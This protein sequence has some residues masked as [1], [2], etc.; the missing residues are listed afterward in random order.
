MRRF[1][2][3]LFPLAAS[4]AYRKSVPLHPHRNAKLDFT[5]RV[6][7]RFTSV[8]DPLRERSEALGAANAVTF[9]PSGKGSCRQSL[10]Y[11]DLAGRAQ[12]VATA[13][14]QRTRPGDRVL[15]AMDSGL[16][17][18][19]S[20]FGC[21]IARRIA[22]PFWAAGGGRVQERFARVLD[23]AAA[24][25][26]LVDGAGD[27]EAMR[28]AFPGLL[29][30]D[31]CSVPTAV[32]GWDSPNPDDVALLQY[33][34][35]TTGEPKGICITHGN[36]AANQAALELA[37]GDAH[38]QRILSWLPLNHNMGLMAGLLQPIWQGLESI[39]MRP[40]HFAQNPLSWLEMMG[41]EEIDIS[42]GPN[43][44]FEICSNIPRETTRDLDFSHW[45]VAFVGSE[46]ISPATLHRF[47]TRYAENGFDPAAWMPMYGLAEAT[48]YVS[49]SRSSAQPRMA[50]HDVSLVAPPRSVLVSLL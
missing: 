12:S 36:L 33:T 47:S 44:A 13:L 9:L 11:A 31:A 7:P 10:T 23:D 46:A 28:Q 20:F 16:A 34:S 18:A 25:A 1:A 30:I 5:R 19:P 32:V 6:E 37:V 43:S 24:S 14:M 35:G 27:A 22:V 41:R 50:R 21:L 3:H 29:V 2:A 17:F 26:V 48:V 4:C 8:L 49:G 15:L 42:G 45:R 40:V 38:G 39:L